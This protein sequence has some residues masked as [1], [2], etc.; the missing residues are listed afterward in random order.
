MSPSL[1]PTSADDG[2]ER[3]SGAAERARVAV[4][5]APIAGKLA[6]TEVRIR[7]SVASDVPFV[8]RA[9]D[10]LF[11]AGGK[12]MRPALL[13]A[14]A[15]LLGRDSDEEVTYAAVVELIHAATLVHDD[16]IDHSDLR[17]GRRTVHAMWGSDLTVLLGDWLYTTAMR[18]ALE[19]GNLE[20]I[21][22]FCA[23]TL[24]MTEGELLVLGRRGASDLSLA[25]YFEIV[26]RKTAAL[27]SAACVAPALMRP[28]RPS[29]RV[30]LAE[31]GRALGTCFQI[32]DDLLD[33]TASAAHLGKPVLSDLREGKLTL[34]LL[35]ALPRLSPFDRAK[36]EHVL[37]DRDFRRTA[38]E[39]IVELVGREGT[40][41]EAR[42][43]A[44]EWAERARTALARLP[45]GDALS[46]L[47]AAVDFVLERRA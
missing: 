16:I 28:E 2:G 13:L 8:E 30:A 20:V 14:C 36:V 39:E 7:A 38:S 40:L 29:E 27:F 47:V 34:P 17:R 12:R 25:E 41:D 21:D 10:Y 15:R 44:G 42:A 46:A 45:A 43:V 23:A 4:L 11:S 9:G 19:H 18:M 6:A 35:L 31:Y 24:R 1:S 26:D 3:G 33:F 5:L 22:L 32:V 37:D